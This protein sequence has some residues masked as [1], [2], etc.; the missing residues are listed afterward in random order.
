MNTITHNQREVEA[1]HTLLSEA[2]LLF[3]ESHA[4]TY[5]LAMVLANTPRNELSQEGIDGLCQLAYE[6]LNKLNRTKSILQ[7]TQQKLE[8]AAG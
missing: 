5:A 7:Q 2:T 4:L 8:V 1:A 3:D 6:L